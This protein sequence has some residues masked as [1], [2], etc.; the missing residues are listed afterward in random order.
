MADMIKITVLDGV[1]I[2][3]KDHFSG[4]SV[5]V[6]PVT[7]RRLVASN[8]VVYADDDLNEEVPVEE[9]PVEEVPVEEVPVEEVPVEEV[10][11][12]KK[13]K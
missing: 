2:E 12:D 3:G 8:K 7:A 10:P 6:D 11:V 13:G 5:Y 1:V 4:D 9:V